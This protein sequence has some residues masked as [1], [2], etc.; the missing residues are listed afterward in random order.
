MASKVLTCEQVVRQIHSGD[1]IALGGAGMIRKPI[2]LVREIVRS[3]IVDLTVIACLGGPDV[4]ML[5]GAGKVKRLIYAYVGFDGFG[6]APNFRRARQDGSLEALEGSEYMVMAGLEAG[7]RG[8]PFFPVRSGLGTDLLKVNPTYQ[9]FEA[10]FTGEKLV[11]VPALKP[12]IALIHVNC[13]DPSGYSQILG[14]HYLDLLC[15]KAAD[16]VFVSAEKL[17]SPAEIEES[18]HNTCLAR[19][20]VSGVV[21][22]PFGAH[23]TACYPHYTLDID[24]ANEYLAMAHSARSFQDYLDKYVRE[25]NDHI[26]YMERVGGLGKLKV[27]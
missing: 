21:E 5:I 7:I 6:L 27:I 1:T 9:V 4:D 23:F 15:A 16:K 12:D 14:D 8:I 26:S 2:A 19:L 22:M 3:D 13:A 25:P 18:R 10:P 24:H 11:A 17:V 20:W